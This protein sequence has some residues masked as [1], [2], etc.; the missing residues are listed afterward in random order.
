MA[1]TRL[2]GGDDAEEVS[3]FVRAAG[4]ERTRAGAAA[5]RQREGAIDAVEP[6]HGLGGHYRESACPARSQVTCGALLLVCSAS[7]D[8]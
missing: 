8:K 6:I 5:E 4:S 2:P 7:E 3:H 1:F